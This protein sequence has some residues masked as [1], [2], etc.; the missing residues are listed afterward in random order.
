MY[1]RIDACANSAQA[2]THIPETGLGTAGGV[3][4]N[5]AFAALYEEHRAALYRF[6][7][8][9]TNDRV[10]AEDLVHDVFEKAFVCRS[11]FDPARPFW[12]WLASIALRECIDSHRRHTYAKT[13]LAV[14][15]NAARREPLDGTA[16][17]VVND[18]ERHALDH[19]LAALP[20]RQRVAL[21]LFALDGWTY[22]EIAAQFEESVAAVKALI[23]R[24]RTRL[25]AATAR[26]VA[27]AWGC[28]RAV[29]ARL[30]RAAHRACVVWPDAVAAAR[31]WADAV[32]V[33][34]A[35]VAT[36]VATWAMFV[37]V[38][39]SAVTA[40][41][42]PTAARPPGVDAPTPLVAGEK[43]LARRP[44][45]SGS[46]EP[47]VR[48]A[49]NEL[50]QTA[51]KTLGSALPV[52]TEDTPETV[53]ASTI[54][55]SPGY[56]EDRTVFLVGSS[57]VPS[58]L[59][60]RDGAASW[61]PARAI[62]L[63]PVVRLLPAPAYPHDRRL[64]AVTAKGLQVSRN[65]GETFETRLALPLP[66]DAAMSPRFDQGDPS[67]LFVAAKQLWEYRDD[68]GVLE[69]IALP[70]ELTAH[71]VTSVAYAFDYPT[72]PMI[73]VGTSRQE[74]GGSSLHVSR[75]TRLSLYGQER[76]SGLHCDT[77]RLG[78]F[79][80]SGDGVPIRS[81]AATQSN[82]MFLAIRTQPYISLDGGRSFRTA[83]P[84]GATEQERY[85]VNDLAPMPSATGESA[86]V[87]QFTWVLGDNGMRVPGPQLARTDDG[88][89]TWTSLFVTVPDFIGAYKVAVTPTGRI[90]AASMSHG[91]ACSQD[92]GLTWGRTCPTPDTAS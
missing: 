74:A 10:R 27:A 21:Q 60:S 17:A 20:V 85:T 46:P 76:L 69:P 6:I 12:P 58:L 72:D 42:T 3:L 62:G 34:A 23:V 54:T 18:L 59:V 11:R 2:G 77:V 88:G 8:A 52:G 24:A 82:T 4:D 29:R 78:V 37:P 28:G 81:A 51:N 56:E 66:R 65:D 83:R 7:L 63:A 45:G 61:R 26:S 33:N 50:E 15:A 19:E 47:P 31:L 13:R 36:V 48:Q 38:P 89:R 43:P 41:E 80:L 92:G 1:V 39:S 5:E 75:C 40:E 57:V 90:I 84:S 71:E 22:G 14:F 53:A 32:A 55:V 73:V 67:M 86:I 44:A 79:G 91:I 68:T 70:M 64:F 87:A 49:A 35:A 9:R 16:T 25:R 30:R